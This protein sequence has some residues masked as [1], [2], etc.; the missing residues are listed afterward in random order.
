MIFSPRDFSDI[1][2]LPA[3]DL[4]LRKFFKLLNTEKVWSKNQNLNLLCVANAKPGHVIPKF[5]RKETKVR[6]MN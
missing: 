6:F 3:I 4:T 1:W 2:N 5:K